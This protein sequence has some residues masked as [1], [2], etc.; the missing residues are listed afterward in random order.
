VVV[1]VA[2]AVLVSLIAGWRADAADLQ[3]RAHDLGE[4]IAI[5]NGVDQAQQEQI[6]IL[7]SQSDEV[8]STLAGLQASADEQESSAHAY[9][10]VALGYQTCYDARGEAIASAWA[11]AAVV[12][13]LT[14]ADAACG[15]ADASSAALSAGS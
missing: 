11:G 14:A 4:R 10:D 13:S 6:D 8:T 5:A 12:D 15:A 9:R 7:T 2:D 3:S 1:V